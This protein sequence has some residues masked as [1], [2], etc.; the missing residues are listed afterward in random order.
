MERSV[1]AKGSLALVVKDLSY[2][3]L[4][5]LIASAIGYFSLKWMMNQ[6]VS[7]PF[8]KPQEVVELVSEFS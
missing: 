2:F 3:V 7:D 8:K 1:M 5:K 6:L 4:K